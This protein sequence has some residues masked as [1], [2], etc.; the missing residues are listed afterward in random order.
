MNDMVRRGNRVIV[1]FG[2]QKILTGIIMDIHERPPKK[3]EAKYLLDLLDETPV[4][5]EKQLDFMMWMADYYM[6]TPGEVLTAALPSGYKISSESRVQLHPGFNPADDYYEYDEAEIAILDALRNTPSLRYSEIPAI[7]GH[8]NT[9]RLLHSLVRKDAV[10]L[11]DQMVDKYKPKT[12]TRIRLADRFTQSRQQL[13]DLFDQLA[14]APKQEEALLFYLQQIPVY[15][16]PEKNRE[17]LKKKR[18]RKAGISQNALKSLLEKSVF[19]SFIRQVSRFPDLGTGGD[20]PQLS[21]LQKKSKDEILTSFAD[22]P[23]VLL[24]GITGSGKTAIYMELIRE[25]LEGGSQVLYLLPEIAL[26]TQIVMRLRAVFGDAVG[27]YHSK[28]SDNERVEVWKGVLSGR[29]TLVVGARS[30]IFMPFDH[31]GLVIVDEEHESSYK[32]FEPA[33]RYHARDAAIML[34]TLHNARTLLGT[35]TPSME[36]YFLAR[37]GKYGLVTLDQRYGKSV[38]PTILLVDLVKEQKKKLARH[39]FTSVLITA[40]EKA[41]SNDQQVIIFQNR[42]GYAPYLMCQTCGWIPECNQCAVSLT[43][44]QFGE[45]MV[46]HYCG[47]KEPVPHV[48]DHCGS[49]EIETIGTGTEK[50]EE[51]INLLFPAARTQRMDLDTTRGKYGYEKILKQFEQEEIDILVGTQ[52]VSKGL[53]FD[54][55]NVVGITDLD[56]MLHFPNFRASERAI[57]MTL[58]VSGRAGRKETSGEVI[59]Q[60]RNPGHPLIP[61]IRSQDFAGF[62]AAELAE[63]REHAYPPFVRLINVRVKHIDH[64]VTSEAGQQ[65][66]GLLRSSLKQRILGPQEPLI[67]RIRNEYLTDI[68]IKIDRGRDDPSRIKHI[69]HNAVDAILAQKMFKKLKI[70]FDVDP[71]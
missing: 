18:F 23:V 36:S 15:D 11:F 4:M 43:Y 56:R 63:R 35:A 25:A 8:K 7:T 68:L 69:I 58:Q 16:H 34:A 32:Q 49:R 47:Y 57:Q 33:P 52:M 67:N 46:C 70:Q 54:K 60:S 65:L 48:C 20:H 44:H 64:Q 37:Q 51:E 41:L 6:S 12:E 39:S 45:T 22:H 24:H 66:A 28:F 38:L 14:R 30:S 5:R 3:Y 17:G 31:L 21:A 62:F 1:P 13:E 29:F 2:K 42:R 53:D 50:L 10:I 9:Y 55:V 27:V 71:Y 19:E 59:I 40:M 61:F 26:T